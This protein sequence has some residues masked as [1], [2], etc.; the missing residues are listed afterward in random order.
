MDADLHG[1]ALVDG[2]L[3][4]LSEARVPLT[5]VQVTHGLAVFETVEAGAGR[6]LGP[7]LRRLAE[8][9]R[10][11]GVEPPPDAVLLAEIEQVR[12]AIGPVAWVRVNLSGSGAR[13][14]YGTPV[15]PSRRHLPA[16][17]AR[18]PHV[19]HPLLSGAVKHR[20]RAPWVA[21][22]RR[23]QVDE[24]LFVDAAGRYTEGTSC[25]VLAVVDGVL[26][27]APW[28]GR[29]LRSTT[30]ERV[31][32]RA[33]ARGIRVIREGPRSAGQ[34]DALYV[35]STT[36][37]LAPVAELDGAPLPTWDPVGRALRA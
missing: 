7:H 16:R 9:A 15:D 26:F 10:A 5:D 36:R 8:S 14:V 31:L 34:W 1:V 22:L 35:A 33:A 32:E 27:T 4:P 2:R 17:C 30:L 19:D 3:G 11:I 29:I 23:R 28:D 20:S 37:D 25:A 21:E 24:L 12:A 13:Q 18:A 6:D